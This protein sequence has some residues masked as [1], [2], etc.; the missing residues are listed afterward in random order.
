MDTVD[1]GRNL[2][3]LF[4]MQR[5]LFDVRTLRLWEML[6]LFLCLSKGGGEVGTRAQVLSLSAPY[7]FVPQCPALASETLS[8]E[9]GWRRWMQGVRR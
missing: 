6:S 3:L 7:L 8:W 2:L 4:L 5:K 1:Q 9:V